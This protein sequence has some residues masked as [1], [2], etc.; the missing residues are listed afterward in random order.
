LPKDQ[1]RFRGGKLV[2]RVRRSAPDGDKPDAALD[3]HFVIIDD[4]GISIQSA[5][6]MEFVSKQ[7]MIFKSNASIALD[8]PSVQMYSGA[9]TRFVRKTPKAIK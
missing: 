6:T 2:I 8:A 9:M 4:F 3:D 7:S 1:K 5:G